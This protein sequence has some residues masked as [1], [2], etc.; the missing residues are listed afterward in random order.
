MMMVAESC[1]R[2]GMTFAAVVALE[3]RIGPRL[4]HLLK[5]QV[6]DSFWTHACDTAKL[7]MLTRVRNLVLL[8]TC[9]RP[10]LVL[11]QEAFVELHRQPI[12]AELYED[13]RCGCSIDNSLDRQDMKVHLGG[14]APPPLPEQGP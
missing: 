5:A 4:V 1:Q 11:L 7:N 14:Q 8:Q 10:L 3:H 12:L 2:E 6:H 9:N 13:L